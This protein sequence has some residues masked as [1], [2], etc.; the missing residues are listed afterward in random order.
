MGSQLFGGGVVLFE[1]LT[2]RNAVEW[3]RVFTVGRLVAVIG[4]FEKLSRRTGCG[5]ESGFHSRAIGDG[6]VFLLMIKFLSEHKNS[7]TDDQSSYW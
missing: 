1:K 7:Y 3:N 2:R 6:A 5:M 4:R